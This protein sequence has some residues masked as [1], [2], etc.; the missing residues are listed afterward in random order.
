[1]TRSP[2]LW[3]LTLAP[4]SMTS[5]ATSPPGANGMGGLIWYLPSMMRVSG[6]FTPQAWT[7]MRI[8][9]S[10][11]SGRGNSP[12]TR[13]SGGPYSLQIIARMQFSSNVSLFAPQGSGAQSALFALPVLLRGS[14]VFLVS[15]L[16]NQLAEILA[17]KEHQ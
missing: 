16:E 2:S 9:L 4:T 3:V 13:L 6:K 12:S 10:P 1:M 15:H 7:R 17:V 5:P 11:S 14:G 8:S